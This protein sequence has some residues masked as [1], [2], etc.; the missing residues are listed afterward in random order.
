MASIVARS[1]ASFFS[2]HFLIARPLLSAITKAGPA[3]ARGML[4]EAAWS[5]CKAAGVEFAWPS[6]AT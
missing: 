5:A 2:E 6:F 3:H 1:E 4:V